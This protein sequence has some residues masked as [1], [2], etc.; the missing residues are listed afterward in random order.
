MCFADKHLSAYL[1]PMPCAISELLVIHG[2]SANM[3]NPPTPL[4]VSLL[5]KPCSNEN[6]DDPNR[7]SA[8][9]IN[10][11]TLGRLPKQETTN[12]QH[13]QRKDEITE[14]GQHTDA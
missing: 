13:H 8:E 9:N 6:Y 3:P 2:V 14:C 11:I 12:A 5:M 1:D 4:T 10:R 7:N